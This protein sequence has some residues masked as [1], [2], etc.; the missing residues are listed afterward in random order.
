MIIEGYKTVDILIY[1]LPHHP[2]NNN[3][4]C[5]DRTHMRMMT[6]R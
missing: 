5:Y 4:D 3:E 1:D 2:V 6:D